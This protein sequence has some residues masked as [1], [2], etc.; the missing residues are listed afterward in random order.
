MG[1][2]SVVEGIICWTTCPMVGPNR[3]TIINVKINFFIVVL[4]FVVC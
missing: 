1:M 2:R 3:D 4:L